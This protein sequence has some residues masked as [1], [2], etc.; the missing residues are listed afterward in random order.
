MINSG[1]LQQVFV[2]IIH[3]AAQAM[4]GK[5]RLL[6]STLA[7]GDDVT[8]RISDNGP[9]I[10]KEHIGKIFDP[11]FTTKEPDQGT[12]LGL[13]IVYGIIQKYHGSIGVESKEGKG[14][15]FTIKFPIR[16]NP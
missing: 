1:E 2:N 5:G 10:P 3:N 12:G 7:D 6:L 14:T 4:N 13:S 16:G 11:F 8:V 15:T 9:G